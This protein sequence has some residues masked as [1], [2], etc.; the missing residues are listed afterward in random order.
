MRGGHRSGRAQ[1][2]GPGGLHPRLT[3]AP[4]GACAVDPDDV[5]IC[6]QDYKMGEGWDTSRMGRGPKPK[7]YGV[8]TDYMP[9]GKDP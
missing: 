5:D 2:A 1:S 9:A 6:V 8:P 3:V 7:P 4:S